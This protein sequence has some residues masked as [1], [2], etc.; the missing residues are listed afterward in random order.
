MF[1]HKFMK[2]SHK[3]NLIGG[4]KKIYSY[5]VDITNTIQ[6]SEEIAELI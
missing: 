1:K 2:Y 5:G 4:V 3:M 6:L